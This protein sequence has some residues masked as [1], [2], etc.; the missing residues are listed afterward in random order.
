MNEFTNEAERIRVLATEWEVLL[1]RMLLR[2]A[3]KIASADED[4]EFIELYNAIRPLA[5][6]HIR[7]S[8]RVRSNQQGV[9]NA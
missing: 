6:H 2:L 1:A 8:R 9:K 7:A 5:E 3:D 4:Q